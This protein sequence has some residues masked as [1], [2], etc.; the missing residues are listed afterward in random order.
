M[1]TDQMA[2]SGWVSQSFDLEPTEID[3][4]KLNEEAEAGYEQSERFR[5]R[6]RILRE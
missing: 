2:G 3:A 1:T 5:H 4:A 6:D